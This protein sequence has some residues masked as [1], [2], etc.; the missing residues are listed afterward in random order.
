MSSPNAAGVAALTLS[1][2]PEL[3]GNPDGLLAR[4][5]STARTNIVNYMGPNDPA[6]TSPGLDGTPCPTGYCHIKF[7]API[8]F[9]DAYGAGMVSAASAVA[10]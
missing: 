4:L 1:A 10:P 6:N 3:R 2:H 5:Q 9:T 8:S 7:N